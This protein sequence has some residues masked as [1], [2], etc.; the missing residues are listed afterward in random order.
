LPEQ[1]RRGVA[2]SLLRTLAGWAG[3]QGA[4]RLY[5]QVE[6][7]NAPARRL[8]D[9]LGFTEAYRYHYRRAAA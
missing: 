9:R 2:Q 8:Y 5:L 6:R 4:E 1:R 3:E 7:D